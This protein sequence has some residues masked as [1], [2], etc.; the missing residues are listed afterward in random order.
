MNQV[1]QTL[2][3]STTS[4]VVAT[5]ANAPTG[6]T[7]NN[8]THLQCHQDASLLNACTIVAGWRVGRMTEACCMTERVDMCCA[9]LT[10]STRP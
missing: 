2:G 3:S 1:Q 6:A 5:L 8:Q 10:R 4:D 7:D 9:F